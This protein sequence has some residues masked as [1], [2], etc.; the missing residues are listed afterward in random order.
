MGEDLANRTRK[1][2]LGPEGRVIFARLVRCKQG[3]PSQARET[4]SAEGARK[5]GVFTD[6]NTSHE[7]I[8]EIHTKM[9]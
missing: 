4:A 6:S 1:T 9:E 5:Y 3:K 8:A 2:S 7:A